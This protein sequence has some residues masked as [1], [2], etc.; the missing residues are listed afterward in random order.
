MRTLLFAPVLLL[1]ACGSGD[2]GNNSGDAAPGNENAGPPVP[3]P[4]GPPPK[5]PVLTN[6]PREGGNEASWMEPQPAPGAPT[7]APYDNLLDQP[8]VNAAPPR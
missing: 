4:T 3:S 7:S 1:A 5:T 6:V 8:L 2:G